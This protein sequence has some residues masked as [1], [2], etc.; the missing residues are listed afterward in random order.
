MATPKCPALVNF[1]ILAIA[2]LLIIYVGMIYF[3]KDAIIEITTSSEGFTGDMSVAAAAKGA[4]NPCEQ[5]SDCVSNFCGVVDS[6]K[7]TCF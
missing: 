1:L 6:T 2:L 7:K 3:G 5:N 4:G